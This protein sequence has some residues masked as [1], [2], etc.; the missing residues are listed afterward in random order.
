MSCCTRRAIS[1]ARPIIL[2]RSNPFSSFSSS[3]LRILSQIKTLHQ[4]HSNGSV[5]NRHGAVMRDLKGL[6]AC[7]H[8]QV[9]SVRTVLRTTSNIKNDLKNWNQRLDADDSYWSLYLILGINTAVFLVWQYARTLDRNHGDS[10][11]W[12]FMTGNFLG[13]WYNINA[14]RYWTLISCNFSHLEPFHFIVNSFVLY[15]F[16]QAV[17]DIVGARAFPYIYLGAGLTSS[18][19]TLALRDRKGNYFSHG[20][21]GSVTGTTLIYALVHPWSTVYLL[22]LPVPAIVAIGGFVMYDLYAT[23][24]KRSGKV[25]TA[26]HVGGAAFG[27]WYYFRRIRPAFGRFR[28]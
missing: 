21:S 13:G 4:N 2:A 6:N 16:G 27:V 15:S 23:S 11:L 19:F 28:F 24:T 18:I 9:R 12:N 3:P 20:A 26:A 17:I 14:G 22:F 10:S 25:D 1:H 7:K 8:Q 5:W